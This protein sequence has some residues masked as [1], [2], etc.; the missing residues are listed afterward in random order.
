MTK[1][2]ITAS[3]YLNSAPLVY[4]FNQGTQQK[5]CDFFADTAP[6]RCANML[7]TNLV[8]VALIPSIEYQRIDNVSIVP[9]IS[10]A[11]KE[12][13]VSVILV[14]QQPIERLKRIALDT[15]SRTSVALVRILLEH[16]YRLQPDY[17]DHAP[18]IKEMLNHCEGAVII[19]DPAMLIEHNN[20]YVYD[21]AAEWRKFTGRPFVFALWAANSRLAP[22]LLAQIVTRCK[23]AK[24]EGIN[25]VNEIIHIYSK[26]LGLSENYL[27]NYLTK[28]ITYNL[29]EDDQQGLAL[30][31]QLAY[32]YQLIEQLKPLVF[33]SDTG[34]A[35]DLPTSYC[36][37]NR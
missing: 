27:L 10:I 6:A 3:T 34:N 15:S 11:A 33:L 18:N 17:Q 22:P 35:S 25:L 20:Y 28:S 14:A 12:Q 29:D 4:A 2:R 8:D 32:Q 31:Y 5:E 19:G 16:Y 37:T 7:R 9:N 23:Q 24:A 13:V 1:I 26:T 36:I 30:F 21:L